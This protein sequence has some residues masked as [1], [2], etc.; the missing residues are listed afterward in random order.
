MRSWF[1][2]ES[3]YCY[4][5]H[6]VPASSS[7]TLSDYWEFACTHEWA[8]EQCFFSHSCRTCCKAVSEHE[9]CIQLLWLR[10]CHNLFLFS[11]FIA[12]YLLKADSDVIMKMWMSIEIWFCMIAHW[13][14]E[15]QN[16]I[17]LSIV[18][19]ANVRSMTLHWMSLL[20]VDNSLEISNRSS[21]TVTAV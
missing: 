16:C 7:E 10:C 18:S 14:T 11:F 19:E 17:T 15:L 2:S 1:T 5:A 4:L 9:V 6:L 3:L 8:F 13:F 12:Y 20:Q 21:F